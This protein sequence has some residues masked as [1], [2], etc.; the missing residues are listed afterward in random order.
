MARKKKEIEVL[1]KDISENP[2]IV[3]LQD[4][5][6]WIGI[7]ANLFYSWYPV[8]SEEKTRIEDALE[9]NKTLTKRKIR[10]RLLESKNTAALLSLYRLL[11]TKEERDALNSYKVE[12]IEAKKGDTNIELVVS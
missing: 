8:D 9:Q 11:A 1:L 12:E 6:N 3:Y 4:V 5:Y 2:N 7:S 10:D